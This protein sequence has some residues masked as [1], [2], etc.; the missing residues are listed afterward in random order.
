MEVQPHN[1]SFFPTHELVINILPKKCALI[2]FHEKIIITAYTKGFIH[3][4]LLEAGMLLVSIKL[5]MMVYKN[6]V[7]ANVI[8]KKLMEIK[9]LL[10]NKYDRQVYK[11]Y[12]LHSN[13]V[14]LSILHYS[15]NDPDI[16]VRSAH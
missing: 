5:I 9:E 10:S 1:C 4:L 8:E 2:H 12:F 6:S 16:G 11:K 3:D 14:F 13:L 15:K 7:H